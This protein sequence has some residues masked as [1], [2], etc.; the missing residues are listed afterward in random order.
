[1]VITVV[2]VEA[3][4]DVQPGE[5]L[6][7][8][9]IRAGFDLETPCGGQGTCVG[10][11]V[12]VVPPEAATAASL[13]AVD[14]EE[15]GRGA[16]QA[17]QLFPVGPMSIELPPRTVSRRAPR[18]RLGGRASGP[19]GLAVDLG[20]TTLA[21]SLVELASGREVG[22]ASTDNPQVRQ[23]PDVISRIARAGSTAGL[24]GLR[25]AVRGGVSDLV[26][27][28]AGAAGVRS[29]QLE[30]AVVAGN[31]AMVHLALGLDPTPLGRSP[32]TLQERGGRE[33]AGG[34]LVPGLGSRALAWLSPIPHAFFGGD[35]VAGL[36]SLDRFDLHGPPR[37]FVDLGTNGEL[38]LVGGGRAR[39]CSAAAGPAFEGGGLSC[40]MRAGAGAIERIDL[41]GCMLSFGV[42]DDAPPVGLCG[43]G[44]V[45]LL[46]VLRSRGLLDRSGSL[47]E[48]VF[49][50]V[51]GVSLSQ[52]DVRTLQLAIGAVRVGIDVLLAAAGVAAG[53]LEEVVIAGAF[54][55]AVRPERLEAVGLVPPGVADRVT[56]GGNT[57][58]DGAARLLRE[59]RRRSAATEL[60]ARL[61]P[62]ELAGRPDFEERFLSR[63]RFPA[64]PGE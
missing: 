9:L 14:P 46:A 61:E 2:G 20:T 54:G 57:S 42:V 5:S 60:A 37:L 1:M 64:L 3:P 58:L 18:A 11:Q 48:P 62:V 27:A 41:P 33:L 53:Q 6:A 39:C 12:R 17:C 7:A 25:V 59:P 24:E 44:A 19:V 32:W 40:G 56:A 50:V 22:R 4:V 10:C 23:G 8:A 51:D 35:A 31:A 29:E 43:S 30:S 55:A 28:L 13:E 63:L 45:D 34:R 49:G 52:R 15:A 38:A 16:R 21:A 26:T 36:V 47:G